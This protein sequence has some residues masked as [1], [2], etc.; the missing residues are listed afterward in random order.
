MGV[1]TNHLRLRDI[2]FLYKPKELVIMKY[3]TMGL[4]GKITEKL[5]N[6]QENL[7]IYETIFCIN[8]LIFPE[9]DTWQ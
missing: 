2:L 9:D 3:I 8:A 7:I 5:L 1:M 4:L 6:A